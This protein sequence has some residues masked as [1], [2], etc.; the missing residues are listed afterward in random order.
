MIKTKS[1]RAPKGAAKKTAAPRV[2]KK[3]KAAT[4]AKPAPKARAPKVAK[5]KASGA[6]KT[7]RADLVIGLLT[8]P[9]GATV[10]EIME[11]TGWLPHTTRAFVSANLGKKLG[12]TIVSEKV[13]GRGRVYR[14]AAPA[15]AE[16][17]A[18]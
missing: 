10:A 3:A 12:H 9:K 2:A 8:R 15:V 18:A 7:S 5:A 11:Q 13:D 1:T 14:I 16:S 4:V 17:E 6:P